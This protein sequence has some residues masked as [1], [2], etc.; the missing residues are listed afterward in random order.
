MI[1]A[2]TDRLIIRNWR[3]TD[4]ELVYEINSDEAVM[5]FFPFRRDRDEAN[6]FFDRVHAMIAGTGLGFFALEEKA[7]GETIGF[8][9]LARVDHLEPHIP[10]GTLEIGWRLAARFWGKGF[11]TE[12]A[13]ALLAHAFEQLGAGEIVSFAVHDNA[14]STAVMERIG[15]RR[16]EGGDFDHPGVPDTHPHL[17]RHVLYRLT[18]AE[19]RSGR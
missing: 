2:E 12:A 15:M 6:V 16:V 13:R 3:E 18:A 8:C 10:K 14:R 5:E 7:S 1:I 19:W 11:V 4:R 17:K 9:G